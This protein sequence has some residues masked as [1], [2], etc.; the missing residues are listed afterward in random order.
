[1]SIGIGFGR[2]GNVNFDTK[3]VAAVFPSFELLSPVVEGLGRGL[4]G[5]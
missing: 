4:H 3:I 1:M 5:L 2:F